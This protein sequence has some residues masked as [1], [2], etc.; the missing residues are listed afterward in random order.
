M[1]VMLPP[2]E[3]PLPA[4]VSEM[5]KVVLA[6]STEPLPPEMPLPVALVRFSVT[7]VKVM[8]LFDPELLSTLPE[9]ECRVSVAF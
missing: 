6:R 5:L 3:M 2:P 7:P 1:S 9:V 8:G 4:L